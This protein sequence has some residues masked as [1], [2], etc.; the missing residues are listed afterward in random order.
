MK[1]SFLRAIVV[2][3]L[4]IFPQGHFDSAVPAEETQL[5][6]L[7]G[8]V[9]LSALS[10]VYCLGSIVLR[11]GDQ[12]RANAKTITQDRVYDDPWNYH[13]KWN[14]TILSEFLSSINLQFY[15]ETGPI[16]RQ[17][18]KSDMQVL[19]KSVNAVGNQKQFEAPRH[20]ELVVLKRLNGDSKLDREYNYNIMRGIWARGLRGVKKIVIMTAVVYAHGNP[21]D[22][23]DFSNKA[24]QA[25]RARLPTLIT[26]INAAYP[27]IE[28][29]VFSSP[30][31]DKDLYYASHAKPHNLVLDHGKFGQ[32]AA[33]LA[34]HS[35]S[36]RVS[37][38][39]RQ[40]VS[41][42]ILMPSQ[43]YRS[44]PQASI[45]REYFDLKSSR[46]I[47]HG[48]PAVHHR[49][50][51]NMHYSRRLELP[52]HY[53]ELE[54][55]LGKIC[56]THVD[57]IYSYSSIVLRESKAWRSI[58]RTI[59]GTRSN[60][61][62]SETSMRYKGTILYEYLENCGY[63]YFTLGDMNLFT[64]P[65][66]R[67]LLGALSRVGSRKG[68]AV[69][70]PSDLVVLKRLDGDGRSEA[71]YNYNIVS[72]IQHHGLQGIDR[73]VILT[74]LTY[75]GI[76]LKHIH[77]FRDSKTKELRARAASLLDEL[78]SIFP[79]M[80]LSIRSSAD[81]DEDLYYAVNAA[82]RNLVLDHGGFGRIAGRL[83]LAAWAERDTNRE[84]QGRGEGRGSERID[85]WSRRPQKEK[86]LGRDSKV[87][88]TGLS[89]GFVVPD[90][91][92]KN[93]RNDG[94]RAS[95]IPRSHSTSDTTDKP[96][97]HRGGPT[98]SPFVSDISGL[99]AF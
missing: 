87:S 63:S 45:N 28:I 81:S 8:Q 79:T 97:V 22:S 33:I 25:L 62:S 27:N 61:S 16:R 34:A 51:P 59:L 46:A 40:I 38:A 44:Q 69:P 83:A 47:A 15:A 53:E 58:A 18:T 32:V 68:F 36:A 14:G 31:P 64:R 67:V 90:P 43:G 13:T 48:L 91:P 66:E 73:I 76:R 42:A 88:D 85:F 41:Q 7:L 21:K 12:W 89:D 56:L 75:A 78:H 71:Q 57:P 55:L 65:E 50:M 10:S 93:F 2:L 86:V 4:I 94:G 17:L 37:E 6:K 60:S 3:S 23:K 5:D 70:R 74:S 49:H 11:D 95:D 99:M 84:W 30:D 20:D 77:N 1:V 9:S 24:H 52:T 98:R 19:L 54:V 82:Y 92:K 35:T 96:L 26:E 72:E 29:G 39:K 80:D